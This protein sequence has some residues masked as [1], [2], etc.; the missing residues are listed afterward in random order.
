M[1]SFLINTAVVALISLSSSFAHEDAGLTVVDL[2][3]LTDNGITVSGTFKY[4]CLKGLLC[5]WTMKLLVNDTNVV[6]SR[7]YKISTKTYTV[8]EKREPTP[9]IPIGVKNDSYP[10]G[11]LFE[12]SQNWSIYTSE[13]IGNTGGAYDDMFTNAPRSDTEGEWRPTVAQHVGEVSGIVKIHHDG[14]HSITIRFKPKNGR[15]TEFTY[16]FEE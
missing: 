9:R 15:I 1:K 6:V 7:F 3:K 16:D 11:E 8:A 14:Q 10:V 4:N 12:F 2:E 5:D 13:K